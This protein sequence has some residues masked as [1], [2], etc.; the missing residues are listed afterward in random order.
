MG[1]VFVCVLLLVNIAGACQDTLSPNSDSPNHNQRI[2]QI[3]NHFLVEPVAAEKMAFTFADSL[4]QTSQENQTEALSMLGNLFYSINQYAE[5][6][7]YY[8]RLYEHLANENDSLAMGHI[9]YTLGL[10]HYFRGQIR[11][12][13]EDFQQ[14]YLIATKIPSPELQISCLL[15]LGSCYQGLGDLDRAS[16]YL[17]KA[18]QLKLLTGSEKAMQYILSNLGEIENS[19]KNFRASLDFHLKAEKYAR[20]NNDQYK[21]A[22]I[23]LAIGFDYLQLV[24][25]DSSLVFFKR[26]LTIEMAR[27]ERFGTSRTL[28]AIGLLHQRKKEF[29]TALIYFRQQLEVCKLQDSKPDLAYA[30]QNIAFSH[31]NLQV[32][33]SAVYYLKL[34][35][36]YKDSVHEMET[37]SE[38]SELQSRFE[39]EIKE[40]EIKLV[41]KE[42]ELNKLKIERKI[43]LALGFFIF[44]ILLLLAAF[45]LYRRNKIRTKMKIID[46]SQQNLRF[47]M[48]PHFIFNTLNS[49]QYYLF[50]NDRSASNTYLTKFARLMRMILENSHHQIIS[51]DEEMKT[52]EL[53]LELEKLRFKDKLNFSINIDKSIDCYEYKIPTLLIQPFVENA[54]IHGIMPKEDN[55]FVSIDLTMKEDKIFCN[56]TD[57]GIG[58][59]ASMNNKNKVNKNT[60]SL[61]TQ[62]TQ[63]RLTLISSLYKKNL[64]IR[65]TDL[66]NNDG[67]AIGTRVEISFPQI[68]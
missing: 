31:Y 17:D 53:Y 41:S 6:E 12:A 64:S 27:K 4:L 19:K 61:G 54:I 50:R 15:S 49:I 1:L 58:R 5:A 24:K 18:Y 16:E 22:H 46:I 2:V 43:Y 48:N 60:I 7:K 51:I 25:Y 52:L 26:A 66:E 9:R 45:V 14:A 63:N 65:Y 10:C 40:Q 23:L 38:F 47:Q 68:I 20:L 3:K 8:N 29:D 59:K 57:N 44:F 33:D 55:G 35:S 56:I 32:Y 39:K 37:K 21:L 28:A 34:N 67:E 30:Y 13:M 62:I 42:N 36:I 11:P